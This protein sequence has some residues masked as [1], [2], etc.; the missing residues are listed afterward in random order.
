MAATFTFDVVTL[1]RI[2]PGLDAD[3]D[4]SV[5]FAEV[6][7][8]RPTID[9]YVRKRVLLDLDG[10]GAEWGAPMPIVWPKGDGSPIAEANWHLL[11][12][13]FPYSFP[14]ERIPREV[15]VTFDLFV[16]MGT[17]HQVLSDFAIEEVKVP[18][19]FSL[20]AP[21]Y[22]LDV[23][24]ALTPARTERQGNEMGRFFRLGMEHIFVGYDHILFLLALIVVSRLRQVLAIV[25]AF[26]VG[27]TIT[28]ILAALEIVSLPSRWVESAIA[29]T[30]IYVASEN[31]W[32][33]RP[34]PYRWLLTG[35][36]GLV[37]GFGFAGMLR[38]LG[39]PQEGLIRCLLS[40]NLG[41]EAGQVL[42]VLAFSP[43]L[44]LLSKWE[45]AGM[46]RA[47][48]S[49]FTLLCGAGWLIDRVFAPGWMPF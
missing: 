1:Q 7:T 37:H 28:L 13:P 49:V 20:E 8:S 41:V 9:G 11:L 26:T 2:V 17:R 30:I 23:A 4:G 39:L 21:D 27:H 32:R 48:I 38:E 3:H 12:I 45:H 31:L 18:V 33:G 10:A 46:A 36:F 34:G 19:V 15:L 14:V 25:T 43:V 44:I 35:V 42:I 16:E 5:S 40:F 24:Y 6:E 47:S 22:L 29:L